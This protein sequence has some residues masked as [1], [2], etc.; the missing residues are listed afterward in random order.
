MFVINTFGPQLFGDALHEAGLAT[1]TDA[2]DDLD[3]P[4]VMVKAAN[5]IQVVFSREQ[6][7]TGSNL[8]WNQYIKLE[9]Y[10][11]IFYHLNDLYPHN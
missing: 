9:V 11:G 1:A 5:L 2:G 3:H 6:T 8:H 4:V 10:W 7:H